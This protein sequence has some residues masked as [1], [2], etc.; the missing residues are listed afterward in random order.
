VL[1]APAPAPHASHRADSKLAAVPS[2]DL[3]AFEEQPQPRCCV[4]S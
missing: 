2:G 3:P 4:I 1:P